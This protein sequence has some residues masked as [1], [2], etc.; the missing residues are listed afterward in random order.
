M[1]LIFDLCVEL[2]CF[3]LV[4]FTQPRPRSMRARH[5]FELICIAL[6]SSL[7]GLSNTVNHASFGAVVAE[8]WP[9][10]CDTPLTGYVM[11]SVRS[12]AGA[13]GPTGH[14]SPGILLSFLVVLGATRELKVRLAPPPCCWAPKFVWMDHCM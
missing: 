14:V 10:A 13:F 9:T 8:L 12:V 6:D 2:I 1:V 7:S 3:R 4:K 5:P 11:R